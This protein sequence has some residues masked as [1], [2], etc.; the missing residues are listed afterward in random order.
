M[1]VNFDDREE[2][3]KEGDPYQLENAN[4][5]Y[6]WLLPQDLFLSLSDY[7]VHNGKKKVFNFN[8]DWE[9]F[10]NT[11]KTYFAELKRQTRH[12]RL[13]NNQFLVDPLYRQRILSLVEDPSLQISCN[14]QDLGEIG[15]HYD[16][17]LL[18]NLNEITIYCLARSLSLITNVEKIHLYAD[19]LS[20]FRSFAQ[21]K[22]E[23]MINIQDDKV[24]PY[25]LS[26]L[27]PTLENLRL[28]VKRV[29]NYHFL[30]NL[31]SVEFSGCDSITDISCFQNAESI[32]FTSC[33]KV[34]NINS[35]GNVKQLTLRGCDGIT[36]VSGLGRVRKLEI[37]GCQNIPDLSALSTVYNLTILS[38]P[39]NLLSPLNQNTVLNLYE[40]TFPPFELSS[41][42]VLAGNKILRV[43]DISNNPSIQDIS[44]LQTVE[45]LNISDCPLIT[46]LK[47]LSSLKELEM[48]RVE[49]IND[50]FETFLQLTK[51]TLGEV[52]YNERIGQAFEQAPFLSSLHLNETHLSID[53][54]IQL[55]DLTLWLGKFY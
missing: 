20:D 16:A 9:Y 49:G 46:S 12:I 29:D 37:S 13:R 22:K 7:L 42:Q 4:V 41:I 6:L 51:V 8:D 35:L 32:T 54:F 44:M 23:L 21:V 19:Y 18:C 52:L 30:T 45:V 10:M 14:F 24:A 40:F 39:E 5:C 38:F 36:D 33:H 50:G 2:Q 17:T 27:S 34:T 31:R 26:C 28:C 43:L 15:E 53:S 48:L 25:D 3:D 11:S 47:G 55:E 1:T